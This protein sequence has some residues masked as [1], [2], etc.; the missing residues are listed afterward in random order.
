MYKMATRKRTLFL[1]FWMFFEVLARFVPLE[2]EKHKFS[3][4]LGDFEIK[5]GL[6]CED[7][8]CKIALQR[9]SVALQ[10]L[11]VFF[12]QLISSLF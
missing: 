6:T 4:F 2:L 8:M 12:L 1:D 9:W 5:G 11:V 3:W 10:F 7:E